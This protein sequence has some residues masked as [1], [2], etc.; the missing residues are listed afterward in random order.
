MS[1][2]YVGQFVAVRGPLM[3]LAEGFAELLERRGYSVRTV[4]GQMRMLRDLSGWLEDHGFR[5][6]AWTTT[7]LRP[8]CRSAACGP[9]P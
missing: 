7:S 6:P 8:T 4:D 2:Y 3:E 5:W 1:R 9:G